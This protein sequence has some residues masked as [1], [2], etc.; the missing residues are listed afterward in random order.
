MFRNKALLYIHLSVM[1]FGFTGL[2]GKLIPLPSM[3]LVFYR[4]LIA[5]FFFVCIALLKKESLQLKSRSEFLKLF[6]L[7]FILSAHW[8]SFYYCIQIASVTVGVITFSSFLIFN[9]IFDPVITGHKMKP[10]N[11]FFS[12]ISL[13]GI[14]LAIP[15]YSFSNASIWGF[16]VG[17]L[18]GLT[19]SLLNILNGKY[20]KTISMMKTI[21]YQYI[22]S[23]IILLPTIFFVDYALTDTTIA[24]LLVFGLV[25]TVLAQYMYTDALKYVRATTASIIV[26]METVYGILAAVLILHEMP[27][28]RTIVGALL[29]VLSTIIISIN[30]RKA[31]SVVM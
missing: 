9:C 3:V 22:F 28:G 16:G 29:I 14:V 7:A 17:S 31:T 6:L 12:F 5:A 4:V 8:V 18:S 27:N 24:Y 30:N 1:L 26:S 15:S 25:F 13:I 21:S 10:L 2:F 19:Y 20:L 23:S 11:I